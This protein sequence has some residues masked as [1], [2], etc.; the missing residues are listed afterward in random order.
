MYQ[1]HCDETLLCMMSFVRNIKIHESLQIV[2]DNII[3]VCLSPITVFQY[4]CIPEWNEHVRPY[5]GQYLFQHKLWCDCIL[6]SF[7]SVRRIQSNSHIKYIFSITLNYDNP[8]IAGP[9]A[10]IL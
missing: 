4:K 1:L 7:Q 10:N 3:N 6:Q 8:F 5:K 2:H 9:M